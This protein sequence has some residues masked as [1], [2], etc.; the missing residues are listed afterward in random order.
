MT[1]E[2]AVFVSAVAVTFLAQ[3]VPGLLP[4]QA[5]Q[6]PPPRNDLVEFVDVVSSKCDT[7]CSPIRAI[8]SVGRF[9]QGQLVGRCSCNEPPNIGVSPKVPR[10]RQPVA[11][12]QQQ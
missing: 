9:E 7:T 3:A 11:Q 8:W 1:R 4:Q 12:V 6:P 2:M 5:P 10:P